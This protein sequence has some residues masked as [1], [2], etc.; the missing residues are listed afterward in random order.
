MRNKQQRRNRQ[1]KEQECAFLAEIVV[2]D[3]PDLTEDE[4]LDQAIDHYNDREPDSR[5]PVDRDS[6]SATLERLAV[7]Y[8]RHMLCPGY[9]AVYRRPVRWIRHDKLGAIA[10]K[11]ALAQIAMKWP[12]LEPEC[13]RQLDSR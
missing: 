7:N 3:I 13:R 4:L 5:E 6:D 11:T 2:S 8:A 10:K 12:H 1:R 9:D